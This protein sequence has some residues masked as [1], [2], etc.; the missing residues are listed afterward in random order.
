VDTNAGGHCQQNLDETLVTGWKGLDS[1]YSPAALSG[2]DIVIGQNLDKQLNLCDLEQPP[3]EVRGNSSYLIP[4]SSSRRAVAQPAGKNKKD[5]TGCVCETCAELVGAR[6]HADAAQFVQD[7]AHTRCAPAAYAATAL[8]RA[9]PPAHATFSV[10]ACITIF[11]PDA[12]ANFFVELRT[13]PHW[14]VW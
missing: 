6:L 11:S 9:S 12:P 14:R 13:L 4:L 1:L 5:R 10:V 7:A 2:R 3:Q 8:H